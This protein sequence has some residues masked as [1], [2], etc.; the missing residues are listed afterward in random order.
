MT[1]HA[2]S[3]G[4]YDVT[5]TGQDRNVTRNPDD[6]F[7]GRVTGYGMSAE[8]HFFPEGVK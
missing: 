8:K 5:V 7:R 6:P 4:S 2:N 3:Y 1:Y